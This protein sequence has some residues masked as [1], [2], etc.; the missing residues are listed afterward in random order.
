MKIGRVQCVPSYSD[1]LA[2]DQMTLFKG[3]HNS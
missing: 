1:A 2:P 3:R